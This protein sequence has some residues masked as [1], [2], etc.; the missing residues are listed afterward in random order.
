M[1]PHLAVALSAAGVFASV[2]CAAQ[3]WQLSLK[4]IQREIPSQLADAYADDFPSDGGK[5]FKSA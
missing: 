4:C 3:L 5:C 1:F 2:C